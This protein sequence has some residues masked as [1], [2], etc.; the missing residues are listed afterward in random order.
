MRSVKM[1]K[2]NSKG[3]IGLF[4]LLI[5]AIGIIFT[6]EIFS[7]FV[8]E[9]TPGNYDPTVKY[10]PTPLP[11]TPASNNLQMLAQTYGKV[12]SNPVTPPGGNYCDVN[13]LAAYFGAKVAPMAACICRRE[14]GGNPFA[15]N[16]SCMDGDALCK[17]DSLCV[18]NGSHETIEYSVGIYQANIL[19]HGSSDHEKVNCPSAFSSASNFCSLVN[20]SV[21]DY[22]AG[23]SAPGF[24]EPV[25][26][27]SW[28]ATLYNTHGG[29]GDWANSY[30]YCKSQGY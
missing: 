4:F 27:I 3:Y 30:A 8:G 11:K 26:N 6:G 1:F 16:N 22:C 9:K 10:V 29:W 23:H 2:K 7:F 24:E 25:T 12:V 21:F 18:P 14:S 5:I 15:T 20:R 13:F 19:V 17:S 28:A